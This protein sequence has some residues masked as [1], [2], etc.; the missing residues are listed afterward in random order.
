MPLF[1]KSR[2]AYQETPAPYLIGCVDNHEEKGAA[3]PVG[4]PT[5]YRPE[6]ADALR[7]Y[8]NADNALKVKLDAKDGLTT[9]NRFPTLAGFAVSIGVHRETL[10]N[11]TNEHPEFFDAYKQAKDAQEDI[12]VTGALHGLYNASF[13][14]LTAKNVIGWRDKQDLE[15]TGAGGG[16][17]QHHHE[18][19]RTVHYPQKAG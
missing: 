6:Y 8:F 15:H 16:A 2:N 19:V 10:L 17:I 3:N 1:G 11:W 18:I 12:L 14:G 9:V 7:A 4:R 13:A 5:A